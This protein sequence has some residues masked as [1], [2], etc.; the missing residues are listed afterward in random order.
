MIPQIS[1]YQ[2]DGLYV[3]NPYFMERAIAATSEC[4]ENGQHPVGAVV[5]KT[6][7]TRS[8][9]S[10]KS[11]FKERIAAIGVNQVEVFSL[12]HAEFNGTDDAEARYGQQ[13]L[14]E[15]K[16]VLYT[17][18]EPCPMCGGRV[19]NSKL[20]GIVFGTSAQD[21]EDL[22]REQGIKWRSNRVSGL[23]VIRGRIERNMPKQFIIGGFMREQCL[24]LL[25][26]AGELSLNTQNQ[27]K[28]N[29]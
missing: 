10:G 2:P 14:Y 8:P 19:A 25:R 22:V 29:I 16:S 13:G 20:S 5:T 28:N 26:T 4:I 18:H 1:G 3:P 7:K 9:F 12:S 15:Y 24:E 11:W 23:D 27:N 21:A 6:E 17:T